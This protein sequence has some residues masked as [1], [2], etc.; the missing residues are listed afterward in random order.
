MIL[1]V[2]SWGL[3]FLAAVVQSAVTSAQICRYRPA[4]TSCSGESLSCTDVCAMEDK[5]FDCDHATCKSVGLVAQ[6]MGMT[7][8]GECT[9]ISAG[10]M[11]FNSIATCEEDGVHACAS[12]D[13]DLCVTACRSTSGVCGGDCLYQGQDMSAFFPGEVD[14]NY[15]LIAVPAFRPQYSFT[16]WCECFTVNDVNNT[17][18]MMM[19]CGRSACSDGGSSDNSDGGSSDNSDGGS[20]DN[21]DGGSSNTGMIIG[22]VVGAVVLVIVIVAV[23]ICKRR[24]KL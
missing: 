6:A 2:M 20:S 21:S 19:N 14:C 18:D 10:G 5:Q 16:E 4:D 3:I 8:V 15:L 1:K 9:T 12:D 7:A 11:T 22:I 17:Y 24:R 13:V 23:V